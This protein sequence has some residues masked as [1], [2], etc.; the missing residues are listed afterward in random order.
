MQP[1]PGITTM[2]KWVVPHP[3]FDIHCTHGQEHFYCPDRY[4]VHINTYSNLFYKASHNTNIAQVW[5]YLVSVSERSVCVF[6]R[7]IALPQIVP[8]RDRNC[9]DAVEEVYD[10]E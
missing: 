4:A 8:R 3:Q 9:N 6:E 5:Q 2:R 10:P 1:A 7:T